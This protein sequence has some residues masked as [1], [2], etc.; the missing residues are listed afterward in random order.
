LIA[1]KNI[2]LV[3][4]KLAETKVKSRREKILKLELK[5]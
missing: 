5:E 2:R 3:I 1:E 4:N